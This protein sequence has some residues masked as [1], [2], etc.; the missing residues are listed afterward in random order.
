MSLFPRVAEIQSNHQIPQVIMKHPHEEFPKNFALELMSSEWTAEAVES[1][2]SA[3]RYYVF[4][5]KECGDVPGDPNQKVIRAVK[6]EKI[7]GRPLFITAYWPN[8]FL[9][10]RSFA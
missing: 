1:W 7:Q 2:K 10:F 8:P 9:I 3:D 5:A 6:S 4:I